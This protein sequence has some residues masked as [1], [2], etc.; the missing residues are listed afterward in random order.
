LAD[1]KA[2]AKANA[3]PP[4][5][6]K[7]STA[8]EI[9]SE[10]DEALKK[11]NPQL[12]LWKSIKDSLAAADGEKYFESVKGAGLPGGANG[13]TKFKG[14]LVKA[15]P[16]TK[17]KELMVS[18]EGKDQPADVTLKLVGEDGKTAA[19]L[20]GKPELGDEIE[21]EG[22]GDSFTKEPFMVT[23]D[24]EKAKISGLKVE[25]AAPVHHT[26]KKKS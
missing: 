20:T 11:S 14:W 22:I 2:L 8:A 19:P 25:P 17:S 21:F 12:A 9:A 15:D 3:M 23:F 16:A 1:L 5:D 6:F 4:A 13:V 26:A 24:V 10:K 18:M 7:I